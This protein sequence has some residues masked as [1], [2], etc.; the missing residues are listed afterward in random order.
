MDIDFVFWIKFGCIEFANSVLII[1]G[2]LDK[3]ADR[4]EYGIR[5]E[6]STG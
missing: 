3:Q 2:S 5:E 4:A 1:Y 6:R